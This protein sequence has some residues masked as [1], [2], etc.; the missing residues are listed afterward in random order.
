MLPEHVAFIM[1]GNGRWA[2]QRNKPRFAGHRKG[3]E[4]LEGLCNYLFDNGIK[5]ASFY[6]FSTENWSR[7]QDEVEKLMSLMMRM[8][9]KNVP[10]FIKDEIRLVVS[11]D[12]DSERISASNKKA[13]L[14]A[15][16]KTRFFTRGTINICFN[17]GAKSEIVH[18]ANAAVKK[19]Q[20]ITEQ[21][22]AENLWVGDL[23]DVDL[24]IRTSGEQRLSNFML[25]QCAYSEMYFTDCLWPDFDVSE[26][27][28]ALE[29]FDG[30]KRRFGGV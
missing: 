1:D 16:E 22:I 8:L 11:G 15:V 6:A 7:P 5:T 23:P 27:K 10:R 30:R 21:T 20:P 18:A 13:I 28:K 29:W 26:L 4:V 19:G 12:L 14:E 9:K 24:V 17:Y 25:W 3:A 2:K